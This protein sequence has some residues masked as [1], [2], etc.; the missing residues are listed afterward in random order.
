MRFYWP[1]LLIVASNILYHICSKSTP[2]TLN[3]FASLTVTYAVGAALSALAFFVL[4]PGA[5]LVQQ[6]RHLNWSALLLG[7]AVVGLESGSIYMYQV[8]WNISSGQ[9]V[10]S[11]LLALC[12]IPI[13]YFFYQEAITGTKIAGVLICLVGLFFINK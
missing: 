11:S 8:G 9:L 4:N 3:P 2:G 5:S 10:H 1:I 6:Y 7:V 13:G 12:L